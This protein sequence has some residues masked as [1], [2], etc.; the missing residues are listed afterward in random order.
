MKKLLFL[1]LIFQLSFS[2]TQAEMNIEAYANFQK[3]DSVLNTTYK[4][5]QIAFKTDITFL[6]ALK[7][8]QLTWIKFRDAELEMKYPNREPFYYGSMH[9]MCRAIYLQE[10]TEERTK[11][12][13][14]WLNINEDDGCGGTNGY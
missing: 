10:L 3:A 4:K 13:T 6:K 11:K 12:L 2:Q 7:K 8:A 9:P 1:L 5:I 14:L